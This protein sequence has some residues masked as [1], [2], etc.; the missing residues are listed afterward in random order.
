MKRLYIIT[1]IG[2]KLFESSPKL[3]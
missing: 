3:N 2:L 1:Q